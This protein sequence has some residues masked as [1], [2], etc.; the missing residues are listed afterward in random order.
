MIGTAG[1]SISRKSAAAF[2][3]EGS[4]LERYSSVF[5][6][7]EINSSFHRSHRESTWANWASSVPDDF[8]FSVKMPKTVTHLARLIDTEPFVAIFADEVRPL[9]RK[10]AA[11]LVQ[12]PPKLVFDADVVASFFS[13]LSKT[14]DAQMVCEPRHPSWF[15]EGADRLLAD[16]RVARVAADPAFAPVAASPGG[17]RGFSYWRLHGSPAMYR[18]SYDD[19]ALAFYADAI[20]SQVQGE[21]GAWCIFDNTAGSEATGNALSLMAKLNIAGRDS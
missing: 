15:E 9:G 19:S 14:V 10:L 6:G 16:L 13:R 5:A 2:P 20:R 21:K 1:W 8:R 11:V 7:A 18:S 12:T 17:W 4:A 3:A